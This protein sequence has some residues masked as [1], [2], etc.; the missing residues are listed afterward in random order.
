MELLN[1]KVTN[2]NIAD[3]ADY[4]IAS[5]KI[6]EI[7]KYLNST[8]GGMQYIV[9][10]TVGS[11][12]DQYLY[13]LNTEKTAEITASAKTSVYNVITQQTTPYVEDY[14]A[15][16][17]IDR[18][19][20]GTYITIESG[21][22]VLS[23][24]RFS[25]DIKSYLSTQVSR[26]RITFVGN[27][28]GA[29]V[30]WNGYA[31]L[32]TMS[33]TQANVEWN[34]AFVE[35]APFNFGSFSI[36]GTLSKEVHIKVTG[37][38]Y[39][40]EFVD[41]VGT[42]TYAS[43]YYY[44]NMPFPTTGTGVYNAEIWVSS[45]TLE[46]KHYDYNIMCVAREE[47][48]SAKLVCVNEIGTDIANDASCT[49]FSYALYDCGAT[50]G[51]ATIRMSATYGNQ[52]HELYNEQINAATGIK[53]KLNYYIGISADDANIVLDV[54]IASGNT[55][56]HTFVV[57][58]SSSYPAT[59][60]ATFLL[61][62]AT[63]SNS[64]PNRDVIVNDV[65][66]SKTYNATWSKVS[67][68]DGMDGWTLDDNGRSCLAIN[69]G[70]KVDISYSPL[71]SI[72]NGKTIEINYKVKNVSDYGENVITIADNPQSAMF[73]GVRIRPDE[74]CLHSKNLNTEDSKQSYHVQDEE[75]VN[76][77]M[78]IAKN[79][80]TN[81]GNFAQ[82]YVNGVVKC[83]FAFSDNDSFANN[84]H[85]ILGSNTADLYLY[86]IREYN[87]AFAATD[88]HTNYVA[89]LSSREDKHNEVERDNSVTDDNGDIS[90]E[91]VKASA[92]YFVMEMTGDKT[93]APN[94]QTWTKKDVG[95]SNLEMHWYGHP[96]WDWLILGVET[97]GQGTTSMN[98]FRWNFR[99]RIDKT[100]SS[101]TCYI[102]YW[103][104]T[105][106]AWGVAAQ[107][108]TVK[109]DGNNHTAIIRITAK[110][111]YASS[112]QSHKMGTTSAYND[113]HDLVVGQNEAKG[114]TAVWQAPA[115]GFLKRT[116]E[117]S[118]QPIYE[119]IGLYTIGA[120]KGDKP[121]FAY[122]S[123]D[124]KS[125]LITMEGVDH[126]KKLAMFKY[127][128]NSQVT[129]NGENLC[130]N[131]GDNTY[132][133]GFEV[134]NCCGLETAG[135]AADDAAVKAKLETD[136]KPAYLMAYSNSPFIMGV[137]ESIASINN[138][139]TSFG[140]MVNV[141][142]NYRPYQHY[143]IYDSSYNLYYLNI[144]TN[145][146]EPTGVNVL[147][148]VGLTADDVNG[149]ALYEIDEII[150]DKRRER[151]KAAFTASDSPWHKD[152]TIFTHVFLTMFGATDNHGKNMYPY[153]MSTKWRWRQDD[154]DT[155]FSTDNQGHDAK[156][157]S[158][159][160]KDF[161]DDNHSAYV[162]KGE[163]SAF[164]TLIQQC[165]ELDIRQ[166]GYRILDGMVQLSSVKSGSTM[167][168]LFGFFN[169]YYWNRAQNYF[170]KSAY[171]NDAR[172]SYE[173]AYPYYPSPYN[174]GV[175]PLEQSHGDALEAEMYWVERRLIYCMSQYRY[176]A[177][178]GYTD[179]SL[180]RIAFRTQLA[181]SFKLKP[182]MDL[183]PCILA[184]QGGT[185]YGGRTFDGTECEILNAGGSNTDVY[186]MAADYLRSI[187]DLCKL[188]V[189]A[190]TNSGLTISSKRL[191]DLKVGD[192]NPSE[193]TTNLNQLILDNCPSLLKIDARNLTRLTGELN[194]KNCQRV[195]EVYL[196]GT[197]IRSVLFADGCK[198]QT[199]QLSDSMTSIILKDLKFLEELDVRGCATSINTISISGCDSINAF[200]VLYNVWATPNN[201]L[202][203]IRITDVDVNGGQEIA[204]MLYSIALG[205]NCDG[206]S[207]AYH[208]VD[209]N[210]QQTSGAPYISGTIHFRQ[211]MS[212]YAQAIQEYFQYL[213]IEV[214]ET[215]VPSASEIG[216]ALDGVESETL[217]ENNLPSSR[218]FTL[219]A[220]SEIYKQVTWTT[221]LPT[222]VTFASD[223][224][225]C[226]IN[227]SRLSLDENNV[228]SQKAITIVATS[229]WNNA[230]A[231]RRTIYIA[232][233]P[234]IGITI[235]AD[236]DTMNLG[237]GNAQL[238]K[239]LNPTNTTKG[240][241][242]YYDYDHEKLNV[243]AS[244]VVTAATGDYTITELMAK[245]RLDEGIVSNILKF[246]LNDLLLISSVETAFVDLLTYI[247]QQGWSASADALYT[248]EASKVTTLNGK[249]KGATELV[250]FD[251][252][253]YFVSVE[254]LNGDFQGCTS[255][256]SIKVP[257]SLTTIGTDTFKNCSSLTEIVLPNVTNSITGSIS[258][259]FNGC[260]S[261]TFVE[262]AY[263]KSFNDNV[264]N[265]S[266]VFYNCTSLYQVKIAEFSVAANCTS[267]FQFSAIEDIV[268]GGTIKPTLTNNMFLNCTKLKKLP[269]FDMSVC[270][271]L[272]SMY[273]GC[274]SLEEIGV[275]NMPVAKTCQ[276][277]FEGCR[278][279]TK[280]EKITI[281]EV[282]TNVAYMFRNCSSITDWSFLEGCDFSG[283]TNST[284]MFQ[285][286][287]GLTKIPDAVKM[288]KNIGINCFSGCTNLE[289]FD[290]SG[291][292]RLEEA[293]FYNCTHLTSISN[294]SDLQYIRISFGNNIINSV[295]GNSN[296][297]VFNSLTYIRSSW[298]EGQNALPKYIKSIFMPKIETLEYRLMN[299]G[300]NETLDLGKNVTSI[301]PISKFRNVVIRTVVPP[302]VSGQYS[303][304]DNDLAVGY[305]VPSG[306]IDDYKSA[307]GWSNAASQIYP[308]GG[309]EWEA[310][311][312]STFA[313]A[314]YLK[315]GVDLPDLNEGKSASDYMEFLDPEVERICVKNWGSDGHITMT[316][317]ASVTSLSFYNNSYIESFNELKYFDGIKE[318]RDEAFGNCAKL[319]YVFLPL[320]LTKLNASN[321][322]VNDRNLIFVNTENLRNTGSGT[323][324]NCSQLSGF[325]NFKNCTSFG[326]STFYGCKSLD[327]IL[328]PDVPPTLGTNVFS[329]ADN[330]KFYVSSESVK[331]IYL[332]TTGWSSFDA[333]RF[334]VE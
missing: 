150:R 126:D 44:L 129:F 141:H 248:R 229:K 253:E 17:E 118:G 34:K 83:E 149:K 182:A 13:F 177:F 209:E 215:I 187:G 14:T 103:N 154:L 313:Y 119:F 284:T 3:A 49:L 303:T 12:D 171:N 274:T 233:V 120:D 61:N 62:A 211:L 90:F 281:G 93:D 267:M 53:H 312:G 183:Y 306:S 48:T 185:F 161:T 125:T 242:V 160:F 169:D 11:G 283:V 63:R 300:S 80:H 219:S 156:K 174:P 33:L 46:S 258:G 43:N 87:T 243:S 104:T 142:D 69:A 292:E 208:G 310:E 29:S 66:N 290:F 214:D 106:N 305:F 263:G 20:T 186:I 252:F 131:K 178:V 39:S 273:N 260:T 322:F 180:G 81:Y 255:M 206:D 15:T 334:V 2:G 207:K 99:W 1:Y 200:D 203:Y 326:N 282:C 37:N 107:S 51:N 159:E 155:I 148:D 309:T 8:A 256:K 225:G 78:T 28:S 325:L 166:M 110:K 47:A 100:N 232:S 295:D 329:G 27:N 251:K 50:N 23:G 333:S 127:P 111:N 191:E 70:S 10:A 153:R 221:Q 227:L 276:Q 60:G 136:F 158:V 196:G 68:T 194:L 105:S 319:R 175:D 30:T 26:V 234:L 217:Y 216:L 109:F 40:R 250:N 115:Y 165:F 315:Y 152:D 301:C 293:A 296:Y 6:D 316:Q 113:L 5:D 249:L 59:S 64:Q 218:R 270:T 172:Y 224:N 114:R 137:S 324:M 32:T 188:S 36:T 85:I 332:S 139:I 311:F 199:F 330:T 147:T 269:K 124:Y 97:M 278:N 257:E 168:R 298:A 193:V 238:T 288:P 167:Q 102:R 145:K 272:T 92:N 247:N 240:G 122:D 261:L 323:F 98:Y 259:I 163:D 108:K 244:G 222:G 91:K 265:F 184:G 144:A 308:I 246:Y 173:D 76:V 212:G 84:A 58:N 54:E 268:C 143:E 294:I 299:F 201:D 230:V 88:S 55:V 31:Q 202:T 112:Q 317:A 321:H 228:N 67:F 204:E 320:S 133:N 241:F 197:D 327:G 176:G 254:S 220:N 77:V 22:T 213:T 75:Y 35:G 89:S 286:C 96:E 9:T 117:V 134:G 275:L 38:G 135:N 56:E 189:D 157:Y 179:T 7:I 73:V 128:W 24:R 318:L 130:I 52:I 328:L 302:A 116:D 101:K 16:V 239:V 95:Y 235:S 262:I 82:I 74:I 151:F 287:V 138:D 181:Q 297:A 280:I 42:R 245:F 71:A 146:Y 18:G 205:K 277:M 132:D 86:T 307:T 304:M 45:G 162:F 94:Y 271:S 226:T 289:S 57:D 72:G 4:N 264:T 170:T 291:V 279:L 223:A 123:K 140:A 285:N 231:V 236:N 198:V 25:I 195:R 121:T 41:N 79:Y 65:D 192:V 237:S 19:A 21:I 210:G 190:T 314:D 331:Q 266:N 164:W